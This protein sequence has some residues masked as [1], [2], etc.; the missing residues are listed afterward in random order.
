LT[1]RGEKCIIRV[2][3]NYD[4]V[5]IG[6]GAAGMAA[7]A[8]TS[9]RGRRTALIDMGDAPARKVAISGGGRCNFTNMAAGRDRY[10]G[11][12]PDFVRGALAR[13]TP[14]D[15]LEWATG[16][17]IKWFEKTPGQF[18]CTTAA[19]DIVNA[20]A[21]DAKDADF[22][23]NNAVYGVKRISDTFHISCA[24]GEYTA[25]SLIVAT[26]G[27]SFA[28]CGVSD[29]GYKIA[30]AFGHKIIPPRPAL[31]ALDTGAFPRD[32]A[33]ISIPAEIT[34]GGRKIRG[35]MLFT[36]FGIGGPVAYSASV[37]AAD[38]DIHIN[39]MP[40]A[41]V[42]DWLRTAKRTDGR[43][44]VHTILATRM[45]MQIAKYFA[46]EPRN[47]A[48]MRD[49]E[50][51][52]ITAKITDIKI[53]AGAWRHHGMAAAEVTY[54]GVDTSQISSKT[55]ESKIVP[56]LFFAGEVMD[57]TGDLGGFNLQ[58]AWASGRV[59]GANA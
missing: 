21:D 19:T 59:A 53:P 38:C 23:P 32:W 1:G 3:Q 29:A 22:I 30:K 36:H 15:I 48:D 40:Y 20:L 35:D 57:I 50:L 39:L 18:F 33:G 47:I 52:D 44:S 28:T 34:T 26:G 41:D 58:W 54:G 43:K 7:A 2:M 37:A 31:C 25:K 49:A 55:M 12:N 10:F 51:A 4:V 11:T 5:I 14:G 8:V 9:G 13:V 17:G 6:A 42:A 46:G 24:R 45:P 27:I 16:H 56:G